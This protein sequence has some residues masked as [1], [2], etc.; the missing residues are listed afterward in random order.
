MSKMTHN[1]S[2]VFFDSGVGG[3]SYLEQARSLLP[4]A[5]LHYVADDAG[6]PYGTK[7]SAQ[8]EDLL[9]DRVRRLRARVMPEALVIAC[10]TASQTGLKVLREAHPYFPIIGTVPAIKPAAESSLTGHIGVIA[11][12]RTVVDP[13]IDD[14]IAR[15]ASDVEVVKL[16]AQDLVSFVEHH[17]LSSTAEER[18]AAVEPYIRTLLDRGVDRIILACTHFLHLEKDIVACA[19]ALGAEGIEIV[20]SRQGVANRLAQIVAELEKGQKRDAVPGPGRF[21]LTGELPF[22]PSYARWAKRFGLL[23]PERL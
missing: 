13:Y 22:D 23:S 6:F 16:P 1:S 8:L 4:G 15:Y 18:L 21:F 17:Y 20:D 10:N 14:L 9:L 2:I 11:T 3:L 19:L 5:T 12:E 7:T